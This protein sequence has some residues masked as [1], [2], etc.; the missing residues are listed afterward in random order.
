MRLLTI[1]FLLASAAAAQTVPNIKDFAV[2]PNSV[3]GKQPYKVGQLQ[4]GNLRKIVINAPNAVCNDGTPA[5]MYVRAAKPGA[6]EPDGSSANRW[7]IHFNGGSN[8]DSFEECGTRWCGIGQWEGTLMTTSFEGNYRNVSGLLGTNTLNRL[9]DRNIVQLKYCSSDNW[10]GRKSDVVL[11]SATDSSKSYSLHFRG[12]TIVNAALTMLEQ[13]VPGLPKLTDA[14]DVLIT[15]DSAGSTGARNHLDRIAARLKANN[16]NV[17]V[18][19]ALEAGFGPDFNGKQGFPAGD[20]NDPV[21]ARF[22]DDFNRVR[23]GQR[24]SQLDDS[25][26]SAHP[27]AQYLCSDDTYLLMNHITTPFFQIMDIQD[28]LLIDGLL[29]NG[30]PFTPTQIAQVVRDQVVALPNIGNTAIE[31]TSI[32]FVPGSVGRNCGMH[33]TYGDDNGYLGRKMRT[34]PGATAYSFFELLWNWMTGATPSVL[35]SAR[36]PD[37]PDIPA[38]D[39]V[40]N[41]TAPNAPPLPTIATAN[42]ASYAF[43]G[44][45]APNSIVTTFGANIAAA[46]AVA[47]SPYPTTL[48]GIQVNVTD[49]LNVTRLAPIYFVSPN[50]MSYIIPNGTAPGQATITIG[51]KQHTVEVAATAP[52]IYSANATGTGVAAATYIRITPNN[53]RTEGYLFNTQ[54][55][56]DSG[57]PA[58]AGDQIYL[59]LYGTGMRGGT[60]T[61]T[62]ADI[63]VPVAG[64]VAQSQFQGLDQINLGPLP[65][66]IG[67]GQKQIVIRQGENI[68]NIVTV[69]FRAP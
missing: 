16:A 50:Q 10:E 56:V 44:A 51:A 65:L 46:T 41:A 61:A 26:L 12:A 45:V 20:P 58:A 62:I 31:K 49:A 35:A 30:I 7:I 60:A 43:D 48:G 3:D 57:V 36:P 15:G 25:C 68:A 22:T 66:R 55:A 42:S 39:S 11:T 2:C 6:T 9:G 33:V 19:G 4:N 21:Y 40:C 63:Q 37:S 34:A 67:H 27:T 8:C 59:L 14:T 24:N 1:L 52:G 17:K 18:R 29:D 64:P 53:V 13:G 32:N 54:T 28:P 23:V 38:K 47:T 69:T 5:A